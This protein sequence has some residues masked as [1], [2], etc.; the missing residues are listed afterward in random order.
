[1]TDRYPPFTLEPDDNYPVWLAAQ[2]G[3]LNRWAVLFRII[4]VLPIG[5]RR[6]PMSSN[7]G[8]FTFVGF[9]RRG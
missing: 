9:R 8:A 6:P 4:L 2:P 1:M 5:Y 7:Y 3:R